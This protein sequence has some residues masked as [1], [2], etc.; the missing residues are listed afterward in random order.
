MPIPL[1]AR[2]V[3]PLAAL[4]GAACADLPTPVR[5]P[6]DLARNASPAEL[7]DAQRLLT[8]DELLT[9]EDPAALPVNPVWSRWVRENHLPIRSLTSTRF[10]DLQPLKTL[11]AGKRVVQLGESGHGVRE[12]NQSKVRLIRFLHEEMGYDVVAFESEMFECG[13]VD[14]SAAT[15][16]YTPFLMWRCVYGV[17]YTQEVLDLFEYVRST[18]KT[19]RPLHVAGVDLQPNGYSYNPSNVYHDFISAVDTAYAR[20]VR[21]MERSFVDRYWRAYRLP[22][23][24]QAAYWRDVE[25]REGL[26][27]QYDSVVRFFDAHEAEMAGVHADYPPLRA[28][29]RQHAY[30]RTRL[31]DM[32]RHEV[33]SDAATEVRDET[34][35]DNLDALLDRVYPGEKVVVW[36]ANYHIRHDNPSVFIPSLDPPLRERTMGSWVSARRRPELYTVGLY[37]YR[38]EAA[39]NSG[40]TYDVL[41]PRAPASLEALFYTVRKKHF[42]VDLRGAARSPGT[43]WMFHPIAAKAWGTYDEVMV[44]RDQYDGILFVDTASPPDYDYFD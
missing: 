18:W 42:L 8:D 33:P 32:L 38:G 10:D 30:S 28:L 9:P 37:L 6:D 27:A 44:L 41:P 36:A 4:L 11:L 17:W 35:A 14:R 21:T 19:A 13:M 7:L 20:R 16:D 34:M 39:D 40:R 26:R 2:R 5:P 12:F 22:Y 25:A 1:S 43:E 23:D 15:I 24:Q 31:I 3:L 29:A